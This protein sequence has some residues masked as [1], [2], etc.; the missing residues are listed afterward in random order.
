MGGDSACDDNKMGNF[1]GSGPSVQTALQINS[2]REDERVLFPCFEFAS[3]K[4]TK[5]KTRIKKKHVIF[6]TLEPLW[7]RKLAFV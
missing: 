5:T 4:D 2:I 6:R 7:T 3:P 1:H